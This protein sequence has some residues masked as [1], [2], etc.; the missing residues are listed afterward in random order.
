MGE[1]FASTD[2]HLGD[3][4]KRQKQLFDQAKACRPCI[5]FIDELNAL[6]DIDTL[7]GRGDWWRPVILDFYLRLDS[8]TADRDGVVV[9]G[10][11]N[12]LEDINP[13]LL[14]PGRLERAIEIRPPNAAGIA[15]ILRH[16]LQGELRDADLAG[17]SQ[18]ALGSTP[19]QLMEAT[20]AA[21][22]K[23]RRSGRDVQESDLRRAILGEASIHPDFIRRVAIHEAGHA[24]S[25]WM[26]PS[27]ELLDVSIVGAG[28]LSGRVETLRRSSALTLETFE[29][30]T[31]Y[32]LAGRAAEIVALG[33]ASA[34]AGGSETSDLARATGL[35]AAMIVSLGLGVD[36]SVLWRCPPDHAINLIQRDGSL[37]NQ[38]EERLAVLEARTEL[39]V[40]DHL[41]A[42]N[43]L[44]DRL[45]ERQRMTGEEVVLFLNRQRRVA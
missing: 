37:R 32:F 26:S 11:T 39:F 16:H 23:A 30:E 3:V 15:R 31:V 4:I 41:E 24:I 28:G 14:R 38:V 6:P 36:K 17:L 2:G 45:V 34:G 1:F 25:A 9:I 43:Q 7:T 10:A 13:A 29:E 40:R 18:L 44:A 5:L 27:L 42:L 8:L 20:R 12:R 21:M 35:V 19:A 22:R 33:E